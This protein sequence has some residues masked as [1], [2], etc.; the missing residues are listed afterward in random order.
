MASA[1]CDG[2]SIVQ[3]ENSDAQVHGRISCSACFPASS[4]SG[5]TRNIG[6]WRIDNNPGYWGAPNPEVLVLGFS[7]GANQSRALPFDRIGFAGARGNLREIL[8]A[9][10]LTASD[11]DMDAHF[12]AAGHTFGFAS[13]VRC[14]LGLEA[15]PGRWK[16]S[17][18]VVRQAVEEGSP[19]REIFDRCTERHLSR[20]PASVRTVVFLGLDEPYIQAVF[21]RMS[22]LRPSIRRHGPLSYGDG[23]VTF[24]HVIHPS[25]LATSHRQSWLRDDGNPLGRKRA[26]VAAA[27]GARR[28][29]MP[30]TPPT[31]TVSPPPLPPKSGKTVT[32]GRERLPAGGDRLDRAGRGRDLADLLRARMQA[33]ALG[34]DEVGTPNRFGTTNGKLFR[35]RRHDGHEFAVDLIVSGCQVWSSVEPAPGTP[36]LDEVLIYP[37]DKPRHSGL[38]IMARLGGPTPDKRPL[39]MR[40]WRI[41]FHTIRDALGF[42][43]DDRL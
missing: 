2:T 4:P 17:G 37:E 20:L 36:G 41:R 12:T 14:G 22:T 38:A 5:S 39:G 3:I 33:G 23:E 7:K 40:V 35:L 16:T 34:G 28:R 6:A 26:A 42:I 1:I 18:D 29:T 8:S 9:L 19:V 21:K 15:E 27:L 24:V 30:N 32:P 13:V 10:G 25:P 11:V 31:S 43:T